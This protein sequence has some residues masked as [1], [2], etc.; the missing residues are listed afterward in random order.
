M[1]DL[2][3][4][5]VDNLPVPVLL[6]L[7]FLKYGVL[8]L[9]GRRLTVKY[10][11]QTF[12]FEIED[13]IGDELVSS[14]VKARKDL[15][16]DKIRQQE[17]ELA[18]K[19]F[20]ME[21]PG[22]VT[23]D[24]APD[25]AVLDDYRKTLLVQGDHV[26]GQETNQLLEELAAGAGT[27]GVAVPDSSELNQILDGLCPDGDEW[28]KLK[29]QT[30]LSDS[31]QRRFKRIIAKNARV[32]QTP[33]SPEESLY[34]GPNARPLDVK[35]TSTQYARPKR[36]PTIPCQ[37]KKSW[38]AQ[39]QSWE[40]NGIVVAQDKAV[41]FLSPFV[42]VAKKDGTVRW[43]FDTRNLNRSIE[44]EN[45]ALPSVE[46]VV[47]KMSQF[48]YVTALDF[49]SF[50]LTFPVSEA[51]S[52]LLTFVD[53]V[54]SCNKKFVRSPFG[55]R[56]SAS[57][58]VQQ[59]NELLMSLPF[60]NDRMSTYI[61]DVFIGADDINQLLDDLEQILELIRPTNL[62]LKP[63]K[64][65]IGQERSVIFGYEVQQGQFRIA[66][67]RIQALL[68]LPPPKT[69]RELLKL[70]GSFS[71][72]RASLP[73]QSSLAHHQ[74][75]FHDLL[76]KETPF[77]WN[78]SYQQKFLNLKLALSCSVTRTAPL[79]DEKLNLRV[80]ASKYYLGF[81]LSVSRPEGER[82]VTTG[83]RKW[84]P[85]FIKY[86][87]CRLELLGCLVSLRMLRHMLLGH[88]VAVWTDNPYCYFILKHRT[89]VLIEEPQ[90][91]SRLL[92]EVSCIEFQIFKASNDDKEWA[93]VDQLSRSPH[94]WIISHRNIEQILSPTTNMDVTMLSSVDSFETQ[95]VTFATFSTEA[96]LK[97]LMNFKRLV[98]RVHSSEEFKNSG[99]VPQELQQD[100]VVKAHA[101]AHLGAP[102]LMAVLNHCNLH[103]SNRRQMVADW[104]RSC[105]ACSTIK[106]SNRPLYV[107]DAVFNTSRPGEVT[108]FDINSIGQGQGATHV[109][110][111][112]DIH[113]EFMM[114]YRLPP[115]PSAMNV[116]RSCMLHIVRFAPTCHTVRV[117]NGAVFRSK[118]FQEALSDLNIK[119]SFSS[120]F[121]SRG[122]SAVERK[123][124]ELNSTLRLMR[125]NPAGREFELDLASAALKINSIPHSRFKISPLELFFGTDVI[126]NKAHGFTDTD[127]AVRRT[128]TLQGLR[129]VATL[130]RGHPIPNPEKYVQ[131]GDL[132][133]LAT[134]QK[135]GANKIQ[136]LKFTESLF[137][138]IEADHQR[139]TYKVQ[140]LDAAGEVKNSD[141][142]P[143][144]THLRH[145][146]LVQKAPGRVD[147]QVNKHQ[148]QSKIGGKPLF[149]SGHHSGSESDYDDKEPL[150]GDLGDTGVK[151][152]TSA[153]N[154]GLRV[155]QGSVAEAQITGNYKAGDELGVEGCRSINGAEAKAAHVADDNLQEAKSSD[156]VGRTTEGQV[157]NTDRSSDIQNQGKSKSLRKK[158]FTKKKYQS[159]KGKKTSQKPMV[160][161]SKSNNSEGDYNKVV[162]DGDGGRISS[163]DSLVKVVSQ[164]NGQGRGPECMDQPEVS[165]P[166]R[167]SR[168]LQKR[169]SKPGNK[170]PKVT[171]DE[172]NGNNADACEV[173]RN[174]RKKRSSSRSKQS[175]RQNRRNQK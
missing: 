112:V 139:L 79:P 103:F 95:E 81:V 129:E 49:Q 108:S 107:Q 68:D 136:R 22:G 142:R 113:T 87:S 151:S 118:L 93:I 143:I 102:R 63:S 74:T 122:Q 147:Q 157:I 56:G 51:T 55:L 13:D 91:I 117:D 134:V 130:F 92:N 154:A 6:G 5:I 156:G 33:K 97:D 153:V 120:R 36:I 12:N 10:H 148:S 145:L 88:C 4:Q 162:C 106:C 126:G 66:P 94:K 50:Y 166:R 150:D 138:V 19:L 39:L 30:E 54:T 14:V 171:T 155:G 80:D 17:Q 58:S 135:L 133:R 173:K 124:K 137:K 37:L 109:L 111:A 18:I 2:K 48:K 123:N 131:V 42:P 101:L 98:A 61:D 160:K 53:P 62:R 169:H 146:R 90:I 52:D 65:K 8:D 164:A 75:E 82:I 16:I 34:A 26:L 70:F 44:F 45:V 132:V 57:H 31:Q 28:K 84:P 105:V 9:P 174:S 89:K 78:D 73:F 67:D 32:F 3:F 83:S 161:D 69:K 27:E 115:V 128:Q 38:I 85:R 29:A 41:P 100:V 1:M 35:L 172:H 72:F 149:A 47:S 119:V 24:P 175:T 59:T 25:Q 163:T 165:G 40:K 77:E 15:M 23:T 86:D 152:K 104:I 116:L 76:K 64:C 96:A 99:M 158:S 140:E 114:P 170:L 21:L 11:D 168:L 20:K 159:K 46:S 110:V 167:S 125:S 71:Y 43:T 121:N 144:F 7:P 127:E 141:A 60:Y